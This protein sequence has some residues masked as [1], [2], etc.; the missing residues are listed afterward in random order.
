MV[1]GSILK[2]KFD[3][4]FGEGAYDRY[5]AS[6]NI[7]SFQ[8]IRDMFIALPDGRI[9]LDASKLEDMGRLVKPEEMVNDNFDNT[10]KMLSVFQTSGLDGIMADG[11]VG[12]APSA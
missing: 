4:L 3:Q 2:A 11:I 6:G 1:V 5:K 9:G 10:I 7:V 12:L 8:R